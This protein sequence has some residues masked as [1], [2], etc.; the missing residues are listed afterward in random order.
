[1]NDDSNTKNIETN[2][3]V[4]AGAVGLANIAWNFAGSVLSANAW[5]V[6]TPCLITCIAV[7][8]FALISGKIRGKI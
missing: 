1:M 2:L 8:T 3:M 5:N 4:M 6:F 7:E